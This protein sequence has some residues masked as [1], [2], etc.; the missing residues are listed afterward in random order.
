MWAWLFF[1]AL[2]YLGCIIWWQPWYGL[3][4]DG[5]L[6]SLCDKGQSEG[7]VNTFLG[8]VQS[9]LAWGMLRPIYYA[10]AA[11]FYCATY[12]SP[13]AI[14]LLNL[15]LVAACLIALGFGLYKLVPAQKALSRPLYLG[16]L[17]CGSLSFYRFHD[18]FLITS[19]QEKLVFL[20]A[21][22]T[23]LTLHKSIDS[24]R[25]AKGGPLAGNAALF[26][27]CFLIGLLTKAQF[28]VFIP[29]IFL[30][31]IFHARQEKLKPISG[32]LLLT[33]LLAAPALFLIS[34]VAQRGAYTAAYSLDRVGTNLSSR[35]ALFCLVLGLTQIVTV[36]INRNATR[37]AFI[38]ILQR[39]IP[40]LLLLTYLA[41]M[42][43]WN[44]ADNYLLVFVIP[45]AVNALIHIAALE[46]MWLRGCVII[47]ILPASLLFSG[48]HGMRGYARLGDL[49]QI[50]EENSFS[51]NSHWPI[52][53]SCMEGAVL[54]K[55][56]FQRFRG[57]TLDFKAFPEVASAE[58]LPES[59]IRILAD[60]S[61]CPVPKNLAR[62][63][64]VE[65]TSYLPGGFQIFRA[66]PVQN[67]QSVTD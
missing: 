2:L 60:R 19:L 45:L 15:F 6:L 8:A 29:A 18:L 61:L 17:L 27:L 47:M 40:G 34:Q 28:T 44:I 10:Y 39:S 63:L 55:G 59:E 66:S 21:G 52:Y 31:L 67:S 14:A 53:M 48:W 35:Q 38:E 5:S 32:L 58:R 4:D 62:N 26:L 20:F 36:V 37:P 33:T 51:E 64:E 16:L 7:W 57:I 22:L 3:V 46:R 9:D 54:M 43:P 49:R 1:L 50:I 11:L 12:G 13:L 65:R 23:L 24:A 25:S 56:Y 30:L 42:S 41:V